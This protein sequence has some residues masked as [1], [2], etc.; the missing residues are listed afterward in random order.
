[1]QKIRLKHN[2][3]EINDENR[4][5][6]NK[7]TPISSLMLTFFLGIILSALFCGTIFLVLLV[8]LSMSYRSDY[9]YD[10]NTPIPIK[11]EKIDEK[12]QFLINFMS[13][14]CA[15]DIRDEADFEA[16]EYQ[17]ILNMFADDY[18][19][20]YTPEEKEELIESNSDTFKGIG[21]SYIKDMGVNSLRITNVY[22]NG[23]A[24]KAGLEAGDIITAING[25]KVRKMSTKKLSD[26]LKLLG[27]ETP[28]KFTVLR[29]GKYHTFTVI[30]E[31]IEYDYVDYSLLEDKVPYIKLTEFS[32]NSSGQVRVALKD[33]Y[34]EIIELDT[35]V[36]DLRGNTGG[37]IT[38]AGDILGAFVGPDKLLA[39][40]EHK[41]E[42]EDTKY[43]TTGEKLF[44]DNSKLYILIDGATASASELLTCALQDY[45]LDVT[46]VGDV[47]FGKGIAQE[48]KV[49]SDGSAIRYTVGLYYSPKRRNIHDVGIVPDIEVVGEEEQIEVILDLLGIKTN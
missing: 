42:D 12:K 7:P 6:K 17:T 9:H 28:L 22:E 3:D 30:K 11:E 29:L 32:G 2:V 45:E 47:S 1:M 4:K 23:P 8:S 44:P 24:D 13:R 33:L 18:A 26:Y 35:L 14:H 46:V 36:F 48:F 43:Y 31:E 20:Y 41:T 40:I 39:F 27:D 37:S 5:I 16:L 19:V 34:D 25:E 21:I 49:L 38:E 10:E 15:F